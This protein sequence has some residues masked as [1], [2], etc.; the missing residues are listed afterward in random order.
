MFNYVSV[1]FPLAENPPSRISSFALTLN[2]YAH[3][4][5]TI[6]FRDWDVR[7]NHI[8]PG[9][10]VKCVLRGQGGMREFVGYIHDIRPEITPGKRFV[11]I[12]V[13]GASYKMKQARQRV[14][15]N[16][17]ASEVV[18]Q[19]A[20]SYLFDSKVED[21]PR[22]Y[23]QIVQAGHTDLE[24]CTRLAKQCGYTF[25]IENTTVYFEPLTAEYTRSRNSAEVFSMRE[26]NDPKGSTL[27][28][29]NL[30]I[31]ESNRYSDAYKSAVQVGGVDPSSVNSYTVTNA[32]RPEAT[33]EDYVSEFFDS[34]ATDI[35]AP[36]AEVA[37]YEA[38][39]IDQRNRYPYRAQAEVIGTANITP[40]KPVYISGVGP[41]YSGYWV[42][43]SA[44]HRVVEDKPNILRYTTILKLGADSLGSAK[45]WTDGALISAPDV[46]SV[47]PL[48]EGTKNVPTSFSSALTDGSTVFNN[49]GFPDAINRESLT[50]G[51]TP[52]LWLS[53]TKGSSSG[54]TYL[55]QTS[56]KT[57]FTMTRLEKLGVL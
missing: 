17:T 8:R 28:S 20:S 9:E 27:Y 2:R 3:E 57:A 18:R 45:A 31:G 41:E 50:A 1:E 36:G 23:P 46:L 16:T 4:T 47:R 5:A 13:I 39:A 42:V 44:T 29:F 6:R 19:I 32:T 33:R 26:A 53:D 48:V 40:D 52:Y 54:S 55:C 56:N 25:R 15:Y 38:Y 49:S 12:T 24:L 14:Y 7:Y 34:F 10:P 51:R 22:V 35:V 37:A 43:L 30:M 21:H 11:E